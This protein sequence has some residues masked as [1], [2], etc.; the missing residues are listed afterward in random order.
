MGDYEQGDARRKKV[1]FGQRRAGRPWTLP[2]GRSSGWRGLGQ[3]HGKGPLA[4]WEESGPHQKAARSLKD[5][6]W[7]QMARTS[8][9]SNRICAGERRANVSARRAMNADRI[10]RRQKKMRREPPVMLRRRKWRAPPRG[11]T[12]LDLAKCPIADTGTSGNTSD[13]PLWHG[14]FLMPPLRAGA[15][16]L[17]PTLA[18][19][20]RCGHRSVGVAHVGYRFTGSAVR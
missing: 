17:S 6:N 10:S 14:R 20:G 11:A 18:P 16:L 15:C 2:K 4:L 12:K 13:C 3:A 8:V 7:P 9:T 19:N 5:A 1:R